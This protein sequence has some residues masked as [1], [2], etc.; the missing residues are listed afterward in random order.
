MLCNW[1]E[2]TGRIDFTTIHPQVLEDIVRASELADVVIVCPH[3]GTEY[4]TTP[5]KYQ[6][7]FARQ[8]TEA[9]ADLIIGTHPHVVQ[10]VEWIEGENG[11][12]AL[13][14]Y[15]LGNYVSTQK[16]GICM[17]EAMAWVTFRVKE[18]GVVISEENTGVVPM[19]CQYKSGPV[20]FESVYLLEEYTRELA[21]RHGIR[22]YG[23]VN[24]TLEDLQKWSSEVLGEWVMAASDV[25]GSNQDSREEEN[26][27]GL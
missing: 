6:K 18:D 1:D 21:N 20:R 22:N 4:T 14:Y 3:W 7:E 23:G 2:N 26:G 8:I 13:C 9:G 5:S 19:V 27:N 16:E 11:N 25:I 10:P 24:L 15:S 17:L 12:K